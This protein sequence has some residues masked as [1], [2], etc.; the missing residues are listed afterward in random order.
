M[1]P[2]APFDRLH[3]MTRTAEAGTTVAVRAD[4]VWKVYGSGAAEVTALREVSVALATGRFTAIMGPS[5]SGKSTL[6]HCLAGLDTVTRGE[7][8][9]GETLVSELSDTALT[10]LRRERVGFVFQQ[11]NLLPTLSAKENILL[12]LAIA[13]RRADA[14]WFETV[15][16]IVGLGDRLQHRPSQLSGGQQQRVAC[17]RALVTRPEVI[18]ADEPTGNLDSRAGA[19]IL[20]FL[21][22]SVREFGQ[23]IV[24]VTHDPNAAS[25]AD[26][27]VFLADG[28]VVDELRDP[29]ADAV[30]D[31]MKRLDAAG[32][33]S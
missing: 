7:V 31:T 4:G 33:A 28:A 27:V 20:G 16:G 11:F 18:F 13:G 26:R 17:A 25:Y 2:V 12:P 19:E 10:R 8:H 24:M 32:V 15:V 3:R 5:G 1:P 22:D 14:D 23:T 29:T 6:M 21:R 9:I 30:L